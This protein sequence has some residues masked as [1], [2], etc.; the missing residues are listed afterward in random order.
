VFSGI[1]DWAKNT[2]STIWG[3]VKTVIVTPVND[4]IHAVAGWFGSKGPFRAAFS[5]IVGWITAGKN[6]FA[7]AWSAVTGVLTAPVHAAVSMF[8]GLFGKKGTVRGLLSDFVGV[9]DGIWSRLEPI[10]KKPITFLVNV[11]LDDGLIGAWNKLVGWIPGAG[12]DLKI[13]PISLPKGWATGGII[14]GYAPGVDSVPAMLSPGESVLRPEVTR[15]LGPAVINGWNDSA[16]RGRMP[17]FAGGIADFHIPNPLP[18]IGHAISGAA[19][20]LAGLGKDVISALMDPA[21]WLTDRFGGP[22]DQLKA[23][24]AA[25]FGAIMG[26][27]PRGAAHELIKSVGDLIKGLIPGMSGGGSVPSGGAAALGRQMAATLGWTGPEWNALNSLW[28][29]E[30]G[31]NYRAT[32]P[33]SGA[34]GIPQSLP[35]SKMASAGSDWLTNPATQIKWGLGYIGGRYGDPLA[36]WAHELAFNWYDQGGWL[37]EGPSLVYNGT[38]QAELVAPRQSFEQAIRGAG[39]VN[40]QVFIGD[41]AIDPRMVRIVNTSMDKR[42]YGAQHVS[43]PGMSPLAA[44]VSPHARSASRG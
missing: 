11:V 5:D 27:I 3:G 26:A 21:K 22:L 4:A 23:M 32:N 29:R 16:A 13:S 41:E 39:D 2:W 18:A 40:V 38:G 37:P 42:V 1:S 10:F 36:A 43:S 25:K 44:L 33:S 15:A 12:K 34:Y 14:P 8:E 35:A 24:E 31:W 30:S 20:W 6:G 17:H 9:V 28:T 19:G 7:G